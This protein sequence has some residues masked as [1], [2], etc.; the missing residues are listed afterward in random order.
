MFRR[1]KRALFGRTETHELSGDMVDGL[2]LTGYEAAATT[3]RLLEFGAGLLKANEERVSAVESKATYLVGYSAAVMAFL[4][5]SDVE[6]ESMSPLAVV[7]LIAAGLFA[8]FACAFAGMALRAARDWQNMGEA[9]WF[10]TGKEDIANPDRLGRYYLR[11][12]HQ[13]LQA[14]HRIANQK[15]DEMIASQLLV[16]ASG[17]CLALGFVADLVAPFLP[18]LLNDVQGLPRVAGWL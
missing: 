9:T 5:A 10:P 15:A 8:A 11:A 18:A 2:V 12:M 6:W 17:V 1:L 7:F 4:V 14:N 16:A 13:S 3:D